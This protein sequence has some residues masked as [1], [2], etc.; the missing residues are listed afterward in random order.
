MGDLPGNYHGGK[1]GWL[2]HIS[3][4]AMAIILKNGSGGCLRYNCL[5]PHVA[6][7]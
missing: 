5:H 4:N 6:A 2:G 7:A 3:N 1:K